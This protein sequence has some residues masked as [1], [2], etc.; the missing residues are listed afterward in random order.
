MKEIM[1]ESF[2]P[3]SQQQALGVQLCYETISIFAASQPLE[4]LQHRFTPKH[5]IWLSIDSVIF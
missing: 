3:A 4:T 1:A 2:T 5:G